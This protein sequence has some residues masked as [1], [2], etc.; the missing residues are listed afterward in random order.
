MSN[1]LQ[2]AE[3][4]LNSL[5]SD[6]EQLVN[7]DTPSRNKVLI[8]QAMP[9]VIQRFNELIGGE[10]ETF[11]QEQFGNQVKLH[12]G[13][14]DGQILILTHLDTV[15][16]EGEAARRPFRNDGKRLYG[17]GVFDMKCGLLQGLY[18]MHA[19]ISQEKPKKNIVL[20][21]NTDEEI[22]ST[23]SRRL[24]EEEAAKSDAVF[25]LE[26]SLGQD[27]MLKTAR[28][29]VGR[30][31]IDIEGVSAHSGIDHSSGVSA[32][33]E[34]AHQILYLQGLTDYS[35]GS[36]L[37]V[38][39]ASGGTA[40]N[41]VSANARIEVELRVERMDEAERLSQLI[42]NLAPKL[43]GTKL[44]VKGG[45]VRP[46]MEQTVSRGLFRDAQRI[47]GELGFTL[48]E[49]STGGA[50]DGNFTAA[51]QVP[52]L[53]GLGAVGAGAHAVDEFVELD[54]IVPRTALLVHLLKQY[55]Y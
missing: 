1:Y 52:T 25:V 3:S 42:R 31:F 22:A 29:G 17:P 27:G 50:S 21:I 11:T 48:Q 55:S 43:D 46:P 5:L 32:I 34:M 23:S 6:L 20:F 9:F 36:T 26:P 41:V 30:F 7:M 14:G 54:S 53:D 49:S 18:A 19:I 51:L 13:Q 8:D 16:P 44:H 35:V 10:V 38:G 28:K 12:L 24:I 33:E 47:A 39:M 2:W 15:W 37:N 40:M 4:Q 45:M